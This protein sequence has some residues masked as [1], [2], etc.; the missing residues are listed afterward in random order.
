[1]PSSTTSA[2]PIATDSSSQSAKATSNWPALDNF[3]PAPVAEQ[4][5]AVKPKTFA[6]VAAAKKAPPPKPPQKQPPPPQQQQPV[7]STSESAAPMAT[8]TESLQKE[9][10]AP[11]STHQTKASE[12]PV[13][14]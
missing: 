7:T 1:M 6:A 3:A 4:N 2:A 8:T 11:Q 13:V 10:L 5:E 14:E 9:T 12:E